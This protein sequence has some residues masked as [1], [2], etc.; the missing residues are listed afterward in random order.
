MGYAGGEPRKQLAVDEET[1]EVFQLTIM[2]EEEP[3]APRRPKKRARFDWRPYP[4]RHANVGKELMALVWQKGSGYDQNDRDVYAFFIAHSPEGDDPLRMTSKEIGTE[5]G[6]RPQTVGKSITK[7]NQGGL[8]LKAETVGRMNFYRVNPRAAY[9]GSAV[10]QLEATKTA[11]HPM[12]PASG[13]RAEKAETKT[14]AG[15]P[16]TRRRTA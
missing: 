9:D 7:L 2:G 6:I 13:T 15:A 4:G 5:L 16:R 11:R 8:L 14:A 1:G 10:D 12:V 3:L